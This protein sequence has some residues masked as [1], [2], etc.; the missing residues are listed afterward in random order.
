MKA[1]GSGPWSF[2]FAFIT[3]VAISPEA[4]AGLWDNL[5]VGTIPISGVNLTGAA[6]VVET[7]S[8]PGNNAPQELLA[9]VCARVVACMPGEDPN[10]TR[11]QCLLRLTGEEGKELWK[12]LLATGQDDPPTVTTLSNWLRTEKAQT[13]TQKYCACS[14]A[15]PELACED[16]QSRFNATNYSWVGEVIEGAPACDDVFSGPISKADF[17]LNG[18]IHVFARCLDEQNQGKVCHWMAPPGGN[19]WGSNYWFHQLQM[20]ADHPISV[21]Y[22]KP[23][24]TLN[25]VAYVK[26]GGDVGGAGSVHAMHCDAD[27]FDQRAYFCGADNQYYK[28]RVH[29]NPTIYTS[30][31]ALPGGGERSI[32]SIYFNAGSNPTGK[33]YDDNGLVEIT[34]YANPGDPE[35]DYL[36]PFDFLKDLGLDDACDH[37]LFDLSPSHLVMEPA[38]GSQAATVHS[39]G[40][41]GGNHILHSIDTPGTPEGA[42]WCGT[43]YASGNVSRLTSSPKAIFGA[44]GK[45]ELYGLG[46]NY[47]PYRWVLEN[48]NVTAERL[49]DIQASMAVENWLGVTVTPNDQK[50]HVFFRRHGPGTVV[51]AF[52]SSNNPAWSV[53]YPNG[54]DGTA[55]L[56]SPAAVADAEGNLHLFAGEWGGPNYEKAGSGRAYLHHF[57][58]AAGASNWQGETLFLGNVQ[59][60]DQGHSAATAIFIGPEG[61]TTERNRIVGSPTVSSATPTTGSADPTHCKGG[62]LYNSSA[63]PDPR[64]QVGATTS[65]GLTVQESFSCIHPVSMTIE[66]AISQGRCPA[67]TTGYA[68]T[69]PVTFQ[70]KGTFSPEAKQCPAGYIIL[71][72]DAGFL[73][74]QQGAE[75]D[76]L[77]G[78]TYQPILCAEGFTNPIHLGIN[79][80]SA[81][82]DCCL[83]AQ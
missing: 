32:S 57:V 71:N 23:S 72:Q 67:G 76:A 1:V 53:L 54:I 31:L 20:R 45:R 36:L 63:C 21:D 33:S 40:V 18:G 11:V 27:R 43:Y 77:W 60:T 49:V 74:R 73:C 64:Y 28:D 3:L 25:M 61:V 34:W 30:S 13:D 10:A 17:D 70:C 83:K 12:A 66:Q 22:H 42:G 62:T 46:E 82:T 39:F 16:I 51:H 35:G 6:D 44:E 52:K 48:H 68:E 78:T 55:V 2:L 56:D 29:F 8:D 75:L 5:R 38:S 4:R 81:Y 15:L 69:S 37:A 59:H 80:G 50:T 24:K 58:K 26:D 41:A 14:A 65:D 47:R 9:D 79:H 19:L 7:C